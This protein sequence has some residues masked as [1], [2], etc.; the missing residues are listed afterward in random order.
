MTII[1]NYI[2]IEGYFMT[3]IGKGKYKN[4]ITFTN[5]RNV[6]NNNVMIYDMS[7]FL[8]YIAVNMRAADAICIDPITAKGRDGLSAQSNKKPTKHKYAHK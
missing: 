4:W 3:P 1:T 8:R 6:R 7:F 2:I 5:S